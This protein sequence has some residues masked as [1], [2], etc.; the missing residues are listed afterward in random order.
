ME[1]FNVLA[2][3][4]KLTFRVKLYAAAMSMSFLVS[5][6]SKIEAPIVLWQSSVL[7]M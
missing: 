5:V 3:K 6:N 1:Y 2:L 4:E 7:R